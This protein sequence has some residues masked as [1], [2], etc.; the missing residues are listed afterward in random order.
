MKYHPQYIS[1]TASI[2]AGEILRRHDTELRTMDPSD[3]E[4]FV[5]LHRDVLELAYV[6]VWDLLDGSDVSDS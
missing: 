1:H 4:D 2:A 6:I 5:E 3:R